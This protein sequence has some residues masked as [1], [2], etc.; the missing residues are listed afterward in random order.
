MTDK[1]KTLLDALVAEGFPQLTEKME[2]QGKI[3][4]FKI[5]PYSLNSPLSFK[6]DSLAH[7]VEFLKLHDSGDLE[8]KIAVLQQTLLELSLDPGEF[9]W[10]NFFEKV[11]EEI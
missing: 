4:D 9:F 6:F 3:L 1:F 8:K 11:N 7:F 5:T 2:R 10:V